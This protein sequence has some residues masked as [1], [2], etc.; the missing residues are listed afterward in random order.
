MP[1]AFATL[2][3]DQTTNHARD[4]TPMKQD[5]PPALSN[6]INAQVLKHIGSL[7]AHSD[8]ADALL[9]AVRPLGD[10]Q[11]FCP[12]PAQCRYL[13]TSTTNV[14]F[15]VAVGMNQ[16]GFRLD[17]ALKARSLKTGATAWP[18]CGDD[19]VCFTLFRADWPNPD[20]PFWSRKAYAFARETR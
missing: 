12:D 4:L 10:V 1:F 7:S 8:V 14:I 6:T 16:V 20:L 11:V 2:K 17:A 13:V 19:W 9:D 18:D 3:V 15:G 5:L